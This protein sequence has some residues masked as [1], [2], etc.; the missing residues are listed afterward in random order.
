[1]QTVPSSTCC[2]DCACKLWNWWM[3]VLES[4][5]GTAVEFLAV[6]RAQSAFQAVNFTETNRKL[7]PSPPCQN[8]R[9]MN[10]ETGRQLIVIK[11]IFTAGRVVGCQE[12]WNSLVLTCLNGVWKN[13]LF[14][15]CAFK[16]IS[17]VKPVINK[18]KYYILLIRSRNS[19]I[20]K[21]QIFFL[22]IVP[23]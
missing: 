9:H 5:C 17:T 8:N 20:N 14:V 11:T 21:C 6:P 1:M 7:L 4:V 10:V 19:P 18:L 23:V 12:L 3:F 15:M 16:F 2:F 22:C 13:I